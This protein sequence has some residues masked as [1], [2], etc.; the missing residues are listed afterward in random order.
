MFDKWILYVF[1]SGAVYVYCSFKGL[2]GGLNFLNNNLLCNNYFHNMKSVPRCSLPHWLFFHFVGNNAESAISVHVFFR[3]VI[4]NAGY[5]SA[6]LATVW[7]NDRCCCL[8]HKK[9]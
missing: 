2:Q 6:L 3:T 4:L 8:H 9:L 5:F 7:K 1:I